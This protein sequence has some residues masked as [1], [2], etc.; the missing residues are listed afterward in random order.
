MNLKG[1]EQNVIMM[2]SVSKRYS[3]CGVRIGAMITKNK[4]V[5]NAAMKFA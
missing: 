3:M 2:D 4:D 5:I 1:I